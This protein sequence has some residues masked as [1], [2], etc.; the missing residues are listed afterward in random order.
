MYIEDGKNVRED[1]L[2]EAPGKYWGVSIG[3]S[4]VL[5]TFCATNVTWLPKDQFRTVD[6]SNHFP[7]LEKQGKVGYNWN[8]SQYI[9]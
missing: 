9:I 6:C 2:R 8:F 3:R 5:L 1:A 4:G 7:L